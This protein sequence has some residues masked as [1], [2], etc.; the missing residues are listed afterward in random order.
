MARLRLYFILV[1]LLLVVAVSFSGVVARVHGASSDAVVNAEINITF[2]VD[3]SYNALLEEI[4]I[5]FSGSGS[6]IGEGGYTPNLWKDI[7]SV[8]FKCSFG[9][10]NLVKEVVDSRIS[11]LTSGRIRVVAVQVYTSNINRF[12]KAIGDRGE[13]VI[14]LWYQGAVEPVSFPPS[15]V[16]HLDM[17]H[18]NPVS[19]L[20]QLNVSG[21][22]EISLKDSFS[23]E[24]VSRWNVYST[25]SD[26]I[27]PWGLPLNVYSMSYDTTLYVGD[28]GI[29]AEVNVRVLTPP[30][31]AF[32][33]ASGNS[34][35]Y[36]TYDFVAGVIILV[37]AVAVAVFI[38]RKYR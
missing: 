22:P 11:K 34:V 36:Y 28:S 5:V 3:P 7:G 19:I 29:P 33:V 18:I 37:V 30:T 31:T 14:R 2:M 24:P 25:S 16:I 26:S 13:I 9:I 20:N 1:G 35:I 27:L 8:I 15:H 10:D 38:L 17:L 6:S 21:M 12:T 32:S 4:R 23:V